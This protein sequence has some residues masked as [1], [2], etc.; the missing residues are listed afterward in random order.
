MAALTPAPKIQF[1][2]A[3]GNP[4]VGGKLYSYDAGTT[5]PRATY[6]NYGGATPNTNPVILDSRGEAAVWLDNS[7]YKLKLTSATDVEIWTV[8]NVG[9]PDQATLAQL[10]ASGGSALVL[11]LI[12]I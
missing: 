7:L 6:T 2:D 10:A 5:T 9:G 12:H 1:F 8:D 11:S 4:L 3:N